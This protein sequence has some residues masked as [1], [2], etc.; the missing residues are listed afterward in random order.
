LPSTV[1]DIFAAASA[2]AAGVVDWGT[3]PVLPAGR[4]TGIYVVSLTDRLD[5]TGEALANAPISTPAVEEFLAV[6]RSCGWTVH[7]RPSSNSLA[8]SGSGFPTR[9][10]STSAWPDG[11]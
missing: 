3:P 7:A 2:S 8:G 1:A 9:S 11:E 4:A 10:L 6:G 5:A